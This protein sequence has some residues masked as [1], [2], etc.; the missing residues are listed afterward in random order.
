MSG[1]NNLGIRLSLKRVYM[2]SAPCFTGLNVA[3]QPGPIDVNLNH[4]HLIASA[5]QQW[6]WRLQS[7]PV[8]NYLTFVIMFLSMDEKPC[9]SNAAA[10]AA[11]G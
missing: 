2:E 9:S 11:D 6:W 7:F 10:A 8:Q 5:R 4:L 3:K 1:V